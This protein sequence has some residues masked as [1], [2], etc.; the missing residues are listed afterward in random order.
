MLNQDDW[1]SK[2]CALMALSQVILSIKRIKKDW[3]ILG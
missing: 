2:Y 3:Y 1:R